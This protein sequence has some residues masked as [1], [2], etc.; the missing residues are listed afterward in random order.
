MGLSGDLRS[1]PDSTT[2]TPE[3]PGG[4]LWREGP[5]EPPRALDSQRATFYFDLDQQVQILRILRGIRGPG[6]GNP[7][8]K[9][10]ALIPTCCRPPN[11]G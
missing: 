4:L 3:S 11:P 9:L 1:A 6:G 8:D 2:K 5:K 10:D 7:P